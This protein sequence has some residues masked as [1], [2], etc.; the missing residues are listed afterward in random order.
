MCYYKK[1]KSLGCLE[2]N[3]LNFQ[4]DLKVIFMVSIIVGVILMAF[5]AFACLPCGLGWGADVINFLKGFVPAFAAF[6]GLISVFIG[7]ADLRDKKEAKKEE[8]AAKKAEENK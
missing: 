2:N 7:F 4:T 3:R 1:I 8:L 6:C 5:C